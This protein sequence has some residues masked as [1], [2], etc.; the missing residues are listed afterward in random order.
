M[1]G[2]CGVVSFEP[3][4]ALD[5]KI[6]KQM[7]DSLRHRGP[8]DEGYYQDTQAA[9]GMRRLSI[10]DLLT[11]QQ[12]IANET[13]K[14]W[15][16]Y[17]GEI[18]N[19]R[20][21]RAE[22]E[23]RG[24]VF[25][26]NTDTEIIVHA[27]EEYGE[28][29][30]RHFNGMF[31]LAV[32]DAPNRRLFLARDR[33]G[34]KP[35]YYWVNGNKIVFG[36]ELKALV[37]HPDV[38]RRVDPAALDLFLSLEYIPAPRTIYAG[39]C[40]LLPGH[41]LVFEP[42]K[43][44]LSQYW[45]V[46]YS[47]I[48]ADEEACTEA[49]A[50]LI[51]DAVRIRLVSDVPLGAF[52]SGG[53]DS[54]TVVAYM[55]QFSSEPVQTFSIGF[56]DDTYNELPYAEAVARR[57]ETD[58]HFQVLNPNIADLAESLVR[59]Q[60]EPFADTSIFPTYLVSKLARDSVKVVLSGDGGDELFAGY[61]TYLAERLY[62]YY[63]WLPSLL[64]QQMLPSLANRIPPQPAKKGIVNKFKRMVEGGA[65]DPALQHARWMIFLDNEEKRL[66]YQPELRATL[67]GKFTEA[68][69]AG[70]FDQSARFDR[71]AQQ[72]YVDIKTYLADDILTKVDRMS[73]AVSLEARVPLLDYRIVE[74]A[75]NL[76]S[77][78]K[79]N[80]ARTKVILRRVAQ[81]LV[82]EMVLEKPKQGFSIPMKHWLRS[83]LKTLMLDLLSPAS[84]QQ[85][86]FF[87]SHTVSAWVQEHLDGRVNHSH[88][89]WAL[90][91]FELWR[92]TQPVT[93]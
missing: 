76:P 81:S 31:A 17:N 54:S 83:S 14:V 91:A 92:R 42:G 20:Q 7:T 2:I 41:T 23:Q 74:F 11:G 82:P 3:D 58:H 19:F 9:L 75:M 90:M 57:F 38:P 53:I 27:Y 84:L 48:T 6:I 25:K 49:L 45:D 80:G 85:A 24:H 46:P 36:S 28:A 50:E 70:Y 64:R 62:R 37:Q 93:V 39:I 5:N 69:L 26:T 21:L 29:C 55:S 56:E 1:C 63:G 51:Q 15:V 73:M 4:D 12:P 72:Q 43:L 66:L 67:D 86:G 71:L 32:W 35:L 10:I 88:R 30:V 34:I 8:D 68:L 40:K 60:G 59:H 65:L 16:V 61:D 22:L 33:V 77:H 79:L 47:P 52:L 87:N 18:Y 44:K 89:L 13:E 78:M